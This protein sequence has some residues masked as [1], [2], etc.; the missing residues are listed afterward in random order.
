MVFDVN[1]SLGFGFCQNTAVDG[2]HSYLVDAVWVLAK[3]L[4]AWNSCMMLGNGINTS[5]DT[6]TGSS[7]RP[8]DLVQEVAT[9]K[10]KDKKVCI[11]TAV[12]MKEV[13][14]F[15]VLAKC[16]SYTV[17]MVARAMNISSLT[18]METWHNN[19][20]WLSSSTEVIDN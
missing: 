3:A 8:C 9:T 12:I 5:N 2:M 14:G 11:E 6:N 16:V 1:H 15:I 4:N 17:V 19:Q 7:T 10:W 18:K 20:L 13:I